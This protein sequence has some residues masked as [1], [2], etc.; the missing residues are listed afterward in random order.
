MASVGYTNLGEEFKQKTLYRQDQITRDTTLEVLLYDDGVDTLDDTSDVADITTEP[1]DG[2]YAR[3]TVT[4]D[5]TDVSLSVQNGELRARYEVTFDVTNTTGTI[6]SVGVVN[7]FTSDV[8]NSETA[9]NTHL[10]Y[11]G[12]IGSADLA[13]YTGNFTV[14]VDVLEDDP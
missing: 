14:T 11:T 7:D 12:T 13:N 5:G 4:L 2:N 1:S 6:D 9:A 3:Q 8:V 10:I